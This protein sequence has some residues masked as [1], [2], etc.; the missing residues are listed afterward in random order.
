[1]S[2]GLHV[3][4]ATN[5]V[6]LAI[7]SGKDLIFAQTLVADY[8]F[9]EQVMSAIQAACSSAKTTLPQLHYLCSTH[10]PGGYTTTRMGVTTMKSLAQT[11]NL[12]LFS[13]S[14]LAAMVWHFSTTEGVYLAILE[15]RSP[16]YRVGLFRAQNGEVSPL[17]EEVLLD[18][19]SII[20][21]LSRFESPLTIIGKITLPNL[22]VAHRMI[23]QG[24]TIEGLTTAGVYYQEHHPDQG[25]YERVVPIYAHPPVIGTKKDGA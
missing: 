10:G 3:H 14:T 9:G 5:P 16:T 19:N 2:I 11:L 1:M 15:T 22:P 17:S 4:I 21:L 6:C 12:P 13:F 7:T 18:H 20:R 24:V 23:A 25:R 8:G